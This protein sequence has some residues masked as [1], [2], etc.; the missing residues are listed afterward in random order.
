MTKTKTCHN[1][2]SKFTIEPADF[3]FYKKI[4]VPEPTFCPDC[5]LQRRMAFRNE[6]HLYK[7]TCDFSDKEIFSM[8]S[9]KAPVKVYDRDIWWSD[10]WDPMEYARDYDFKR[11]FFEQFNDLIKNVPWPSRSA[12]YLVDSDYSMNASYL[13]NCYLIFASGYSEDCAYGYQVGYSK[14]CYDNSYLAKCELCYGS[15]E[16]AGCYKTFFS[17]NCA[18][19][20]D[21][22][23]CEDCINCQ[24]CFGCTNLRHKKY[25]IFNQP[26]SKEEYFKKL[27]EF[28]LGSY[29]SISEL[30]EKT[31]EL[32]LK[33]PVKF[34]LGRH[35]NNVTGNDIYNS[36][37]VFDSYNIQGGED[38]RYCQFVEYRG[39]EDCY[40]YTSWG[41]KAKLVYEAAGVG[42]RVNR[43]KFCFNCYI[44]C[45]NLEYCFH[46]NSSSNL[47]G[48]LGLRHKQYCILNKQY[49]K[50]EYETL[51]PKIKE[52][53]NK[54]PYKDQRGRIYKY[55]E[56]FPI[57]LSPFTY[58]ETMVQEHFPLTKEQALEQGYLW[59]DKPKAEYQPTIK[60]KDLPDHI[61]DIDR[62][63]LKEIIE[64]Q[65]GTVPEA[66]GTVPDSCQGSG[67]FRIIPQE[68]KF[69]KKMNLP[70]PRLCPD[71]R[72]Q[73]RIKQRNP[74][75]LWERKCQCAGNKSSNK[76]Y[77]NTIEH[78]H[79]NKPCPNTFQTTYSPKRKEIV[80]C[81]ACYLKE[82]G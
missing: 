78:S 10:K 14:D 29:K 55:G 82:V 7:R 69:Y 57:E 80:Y 17:S 79:K 64:C 3:E 16:S 23:F 59:Y 77:Q 48:C 81:E 42:R 45:R 51:V 20:Q 31:K 15:F 13:K 32:H 22:Y 60:A 75:K 4:G 38:L 28:N 2:K 39:V 67:V 74:L 47:F 65:T 26:Y 61:K 18:D 30:K 24:N 40:D 27:K 66:S 46:C 58:N 73:E 11:P 56:F 5:R 49:S 6:R 50:E 72:H 9:P 33:F 76:L 54:I 25:H 71:C 12:T 35:N 36:K 68:L 8:F 1:C 62:S 34:M 70:L 52:Q 19:C 21:I 44:D 53:M 43:I 37:N 63:I 41:E